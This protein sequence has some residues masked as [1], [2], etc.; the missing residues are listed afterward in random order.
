[1]HLTVPVLQRRLRYDDEMRSGDAEMVLKIAE[2]RDGL[3]RFAETLL[4]SAVRYGRF[5]AISTDHLV[6]QYPIDTVVMQ[7]GHPIETL[8]LVVPHFTSLDI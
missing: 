6:G 2:E 1:M 7:R 3:Q 4:R 8:H 5:Q